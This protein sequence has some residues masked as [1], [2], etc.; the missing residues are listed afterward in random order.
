M[1]RLPAL[2]AAAFICAAANAQYWKAIGLGTVGPTEIQTLYGDSISDRLLAGGPFLKII[3]ENDTV[4]AYGQAAWN[5]NRWD[6]IAH[7]IA[8]AEGQTFWFLRFQGKLYSC[9]GYIFLTPGGEANA[10]FARLNEDTK[11]WEALECVN[12]DFGGM[13]T[14][15]PKEPDTTLYAT[16]YMGS[17]CG[18]PPSCVFRY[19]GSAFH[20]WEPFN[21]IPD[22]NDNYVGTVFDFQ[23]KTY[24]TCSLPDPTGPGFVSFIRWNGNSW[25]HVPGWN[26]LSPIKDI[27]IHNDTLY[28]A[29]TFSLA[30]G[31]P[32][33]LVAAFDGENWNDMDGGLAYTWA[34]M[35]GAALDLEWFHGELWTCGLFNQAG[36]IPAHSIAHWDGN[37]WCVPPGDFRQ[38]NYNYLSRLGD[39]AVWR[40]SL[41]VCGSIAYIDW[42]PAY[43]VAQWI[44][45]DALEECSTVG[46]DEENAQKDHLIA[47]PLPGGSTWYVHFPHSGNWIL[48]TY[49]AV[50][51]RT[52]QVKV[53]GEA[54]ELDF[55]KESSGM[56]VLRAHADNGA[57]CQTKLLNP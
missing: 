13:L 20:I 52:R 4:L 23:G 44:G 5:G 47:T 9:G 51:R 41:Y 31:G 43:Q 14:L 1:K 6:S 22:G 45:G 7:R 19:D 57:I 38:S 42:E 56:Y 17:V 8:P 34:P 24:M 15:V 12:A 49:D 11:Y 18:Y 50:G 25:E 30:D 36:D 21:Q 26:T 28:V 3:N 39:M 29:G 27:S 10:S 48:E 33:N 53:V 37:H 55:S 2:L 35:S 54:L 16:G 46:I 40:D 32:G